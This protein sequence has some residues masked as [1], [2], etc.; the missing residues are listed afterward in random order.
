MAKVILL[1]QAEYAKH[2]D[3]S[4]VAVHKAVKAGRISLIDGKIDPAVADIQWAQNTRAR[5]TARPA[6]AAADA[7]AQ[8]QA[9][10]SGQDASD[11]RPGDEDYWQSRSRREAAEASIAELKRDE[12]TGELIRTE[13]VRAGMASILAATRDRLMQLPV[14]LAPV[15]A[16]ESDQ[17]KVHDLVREEIHAALSQLANAGPQVGLQP[18][19]E[20]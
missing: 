2:R 20:P 13:V 9:P 4:A 7:P 19:S 5:V 17:A 3:C 10:L 15:L 1:T 6:P 11:A 12:L 16:A 8:P 14:R 18:E